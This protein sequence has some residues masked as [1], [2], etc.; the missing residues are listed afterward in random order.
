M[1][2]LVGISGN[3][4]IAAASVMKVDVSSFHRTVRITLMDGSVVEHS[5]DLG[6]QLYREVDRLV[7][8]INGT[9]ADTGEKEAMEA[10]MERIDPATYPGL[11]TAERAAL[12]RFAKPAGW[13][14][15]NEVEE[16]HE[17]P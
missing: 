4:F 8:Q 12:G 15:Q 17:L 16:T 6:A 3:R 2:R 14:I 13:N 11:T 9:T 10:V 7:A 5:P 1:S